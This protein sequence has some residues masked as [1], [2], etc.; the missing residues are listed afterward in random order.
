M[1]TAK[2]VASEKM[3]KNRPAHDTDGHQTDALRLLPDAASV[4]KLVTYRIFVTFILSLTMN[5]SFCFQFA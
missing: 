3:E 2:N 1:L 5:I 4:I